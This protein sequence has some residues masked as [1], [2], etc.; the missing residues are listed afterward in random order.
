DEDLLRRTAENESLQVAA[1]LDSNGTV[2][3]SS[4][5]LSP[6]LKALAR[7]VAFGHKRLS[8]TLFHRLPGAEAGAVCVGRMQGGA[9][10]LSLDMHGLRNRIIKVSARRA[11]DE[12]SGASGALYAAVTDNASEIIGFTG[13]PYDDIFENGLKSWSIP[14]PG[15]SISRRIQLDDKIVLQVSAPLLLDSE[16]YGAIHVGMDSSGAAM[17]ITRMRRTVLASTGLL[18]AVAFLS[19]WMLYRNQNRHLAKLREMQLQLDRAERLSALGGLAAGVAHEIRNPLNAISMAA[20]RL[21]RGDVRELTEVIRD[22]IRRL[23]EIVE[24]FLSFSRT[25]S[26]RLESQDLNEIVRQFVILVEEEARSRGVDLVANL[27]SDPVMVQADADKLRQAI[28]N[29][30]RNALEAVSDSGLVT[31]SLEKLKSGRAAVHIED[32]GRGLTREQ[33]DHMF[34]PDFTTKEKGLGL[35]LAIAHEIIAGH[36]GE[37]QVESRPGKGSKFTI[38]LP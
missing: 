38:L 1:M 34:D 23:N 12:V 27:A 22:E 35:G 31:V 9:V 36:G 13:Q 30:T 29:I 37:I 8:I 11:L 18:I 16:S 19:M 26:L 4:G 17:L 33:I 10:L 3:L 24:G 15:A 28:F 21:N 14:T 7:P 6:Q 5:E 2:V 20:Q 32:N 25:G